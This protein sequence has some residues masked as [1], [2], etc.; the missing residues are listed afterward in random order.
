MSDMEAHR[1][2][3]VPLWLVGNTLEERAESLCN[4]VE[5]KKD[6]SH[7]SWVD[8]INDLGYRKFYI[9][10]PAIYE[11]HDIELDACGFSEASNNEDGGINYFMLYHNG[12]ASFDEALD[13]AVEKIEDES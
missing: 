9:R 4:R 6:E 8:C 3:L 13:G 11:I 10:G 1:G 5:F 12:G 7:S 2:K